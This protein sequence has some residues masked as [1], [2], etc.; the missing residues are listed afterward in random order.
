[1]EQEDTLLRVVIRNEA[2]K[3]LPN[4]CVIHVELEA[5]FYLTESFEKPDSWQVGIGYMTMTDDV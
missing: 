2:K 5:P 3:I 4:V 1:M